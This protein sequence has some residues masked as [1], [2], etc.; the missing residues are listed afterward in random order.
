MDYGMYAAAILVAFDVILT[1]CAILYTF[2]RGKAEGRR[3]VL[4]ALTDE[5][6]IKTGLETIFEQVT[7]ENVLDTIKKHFLMETAPDKFVLNDQTY[8]LLHIVYMEAAGMLQRSGDG[9]AGAIERR[10]SGGALIKNSGWIHD[11]LMLADHPL[12]KKFLGLDGKK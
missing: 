5:E 12:A 7:P 10:G 11:I 2:R 4:E 1:V 6:F 9:A 8:N 3:A